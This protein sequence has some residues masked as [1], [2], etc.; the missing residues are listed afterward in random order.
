[1]VTRTEW[2]LRGDSEIAAPTEIVEPRAIVR[3]DRKARPAHAAFGRLPR[4]RTAAGV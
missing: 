3:P 2:T 4:A 1:M